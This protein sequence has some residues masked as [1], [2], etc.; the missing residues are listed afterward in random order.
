MVRRRAVR[1][2]KPSIHFESGSFA[3]RERANRCNASTGDE[4][5]PR[6]TGLR[7]GND[8]AA[9]CVA[10]LLEPAKGNEDLLERADAVAQTGCVLVAPALRKVP[11]ACA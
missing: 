3:A 8:E 9:A 6:K 10:Q 11:K 2:G 1:L 4:D 7:G 5:P